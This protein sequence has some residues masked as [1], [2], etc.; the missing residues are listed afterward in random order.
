MANLFAGLSYGFWLRKHNKHHQKPNQIGEDPDIAI[1]VLSFTPESRDEKKG[2][3][4]WFT[5]RQGY[6]F[7][8]L[9]CYFTGFDLAPRQ[10]GKPEAQ[11]AQD[12]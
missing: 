5:N 3:E 8:L 6:L 7:P 12:R 11:R 10:H 9:A 1:R 2:I 4:R